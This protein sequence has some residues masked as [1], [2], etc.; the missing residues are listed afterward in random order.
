VIGVQPAASDVMRQ[1]VAAGRIVDAPSSDTLSDATAGRFSLPH[2]S[3]AVVSCHVMSCHKSLLMR[4]FYNVFCFFLCGRSTLLL[5][6]QPTLQQG[7]DG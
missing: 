4:V 5:S 2:A 7:C 6:A 1:S 3:T